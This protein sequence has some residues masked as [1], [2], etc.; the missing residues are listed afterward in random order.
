MHRSLIVALALI[1][2]LTVLA[3]DGPRIAVSPQSSLAGEPVDIV[4][5]GLVPWTRATVR[6][7]RTIDEKPY[8]S[9]ADYQADSRGVIQVHAQAPLAGSYSGVDPFGL[10]WSMQKVEGAPEEGRADP[11]AADGDDEPTKKDADPTELP[12]PKPHQL[13]VSVGGE[14]VATATLELV[15]VAEGVRTEWVD[16]GRLRGVLWLPPGDGPHPA[17]LVV[18]GSGG[19]Y[20]KLNALRL[21]NRGYAALA[22]AYFAA[23]DLP[24]QLAEIP[25][26]YFIEGIDWLSEQSTIDADRLGVTGGSRGGEL[27]LLLASIEPRLKAVVSWVPSHVTWAGCCDETTYGRSSWTLDGEPLP[28][29]DD[30]E[31]AWVAPRYWPEAEGFLGP[32]WLSLANERGVEDAVI[33]VE[34]SEAAILLISG[35]RDELWPS[36]YMA[37]QVM[38][39]LEANAYGYP[40]VHVL[41]DD[42]GHAVGAASPDYPVDPLIETVHPIGQIPMRLGGTREAMASAPREAWRL[43]EEFL[44][45]NL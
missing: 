35:G 6:L 26:E 5:S 31:V 44:D 23:P 45:Q 43:I 39:R 36:S 32:F 8:A 18:S 10:F 22:L 16:D 13:S 29:V 14:I 30:S 37:D 15:Y 9:E 42:A 12:E 4:V 38:A 27:S 28:F 20:P 3:D 21:A 40:F 41:F 17:M 19:G 24:D 33:P 25:L 11:K 7:E 34:R 2:P 1:A